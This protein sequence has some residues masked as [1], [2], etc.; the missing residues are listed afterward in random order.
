MKKPKQKTQMPDEEASVVAE[1]KA[2]IDE[3]P[4]YGYRRVQ[5]ILNQQRK[6]K[7]LMPINH[8]RVYRLMGVHDM[9]LPKYGRVKLSRTHTGKVMTLKSNLRWCSD[10]FSILCDNGDQV[11]VAFS[12]DTCDR[13]V[14]RYTA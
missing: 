14:M 6:V 8:K 10:G 1:I 3:R 7:N 9:L 5:A 13:V 12:L 4:T 11:Y 2:I